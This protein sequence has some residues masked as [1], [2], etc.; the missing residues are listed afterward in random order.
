MCDFRQMTCNISKAAQDGHIFTKGEPDVVHAVSTVL[1]A[2]SD[3]HVTTPNHPSAYL[4][5]FQS[6]DLHIFGT[7][8]VKLGIP[9]LV[10]GLQ[11][12]DRREYLRTM[13]DYPLPGVYDP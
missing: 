13:I 5:H 1:L 12:A 8:Q 9:K 7:Q 2:L 6:S 11:T 3:L 10:C 4:L